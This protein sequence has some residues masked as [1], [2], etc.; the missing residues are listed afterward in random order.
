[1]DQIAGVRFGQREAGLH[2]QGGHPGRGHGAELFHCPLDVHAVQQL[3]DVVEGSLLGHA[4]V[5]Q[6][7]GMRA[8]QV[9]GGLGLAL[10]AP[11][12][13]RVVLPG[14]VLGSDELDRS[15]TRE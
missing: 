4:K 13:H 5:V 12:Q 3:H 1:M 11:S 15:R 10:E 6:S 9:G 7:D 2:E 14:Q 8:R